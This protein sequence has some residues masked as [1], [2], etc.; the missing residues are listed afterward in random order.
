MDDVENNF[1]NSWEGCFE[2]SI[3]TWGHIVKKRQE[4]SGWCTLGERARLHDIEGKGDLWIH[5]C[6]DCG[7]QH[8][9]GA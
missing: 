4:K 9:L 8:G 5:V 3:A 1:N 6:G 7:V 2:C